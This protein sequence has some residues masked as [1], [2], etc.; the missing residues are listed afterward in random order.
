MT[1]EVE[2]KF[3]LESHE[4]VVQKL[5]ELK[6]EPASTV[7]QQDTYFNHP[8][9]DFAQTDEAV[10]IVDYKTNRPPPND[11]RDVPPIYLRQMA[12]YRAV[13]R[14]IYPLL[15]IRCALLWTD[16][17]RLMQISEELLEPWAP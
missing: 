11:A 8:S 4:P 15:T 9:R 2:L 12:A 13:L 5:A 16:G 10:R 6:A 14:E 7:E 3:P 1:F 17:P